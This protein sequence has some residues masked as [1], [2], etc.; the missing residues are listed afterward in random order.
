MVTIPL[1]VYDEVVV[2][3]EG[4]PGARDVAEAAWIHV[5]QV[6]HIDAVQKFS[7]FLH[8]GESEAIVLAEEMGADLIILDDNRAR[9]AARVRGFRVVGTLAILRQAKEKGFISALK[10]VLDDLRSADFYIGKEYDEILKDVGE[11]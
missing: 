11:I 9:K 7:S 1:Q 3:G 4:K 10:P 6:K 5:K 8:V 2:R